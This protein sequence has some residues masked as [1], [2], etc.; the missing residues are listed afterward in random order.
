[1][2]KWVTGPESLSLITWAPN[3]FPLYPGADNTSVG[4]GFGVESLHRQFAAGQFAL[5]VVRISIF[6]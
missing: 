3:H 4:R 5:E 6:R 1:M 2:G